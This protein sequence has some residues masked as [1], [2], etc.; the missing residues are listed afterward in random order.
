MKEEIKL[1]TPEAIVTEEEQKKLKEKQQKEL[2]AYAADI[3]EVN[4]KHNM[5]IVP[6]AKLEVQYIEEPKA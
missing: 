5:R 3:E 1:P 4:K 2:E 6:T